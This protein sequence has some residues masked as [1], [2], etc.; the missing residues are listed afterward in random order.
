[1]WRRIVCA[2]GLC[3]AVAAGESLLQRKRVQ[4]QAFAARSD[5]E[6]AN[7]SSE[8]EETP[9][10]VQEVLDVNGPLPPNFRDQFIS[11]VLQAMKKVEIAVK[12]D[13]IHVSGSKPVESGISGMNVQEIEFT[14]PEKVAH[15]IRKEA[16]NEGSPLAMG[17][18]E[19]YLVAKE[20]VGIPAPPVPNPVDLDTD[21]TTAGFGDLEPFGTEDTANELTNDSIEQSDKMV[22]QME[23]AE[24]AEE[25][26]AV[27]RALTRLRGAAITSFD[28]VAREQTGNID[29]YTGRVGSFRTR[30]PVK[31]LAHAESDTAEWAF[32]NA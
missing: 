5:G 26:R 7:K 13:E 22:D 25:K 9:R 11:G 24:I 28:G 2:S 3:G 14:A 20:D 16:A 4:G 23:K 8:E 6:P 15:E 19:T 30:H 10:I 31:H 32:P 1:M 27:F 17:V 21:M 29:G 12:S 18:L